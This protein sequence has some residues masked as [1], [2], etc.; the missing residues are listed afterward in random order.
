MLYALL[1]PLAVIAVTIMFLDR[2]G[3]PIRIEGVE[4]GSEP[5]A[6]D[7]VEHPPQPDQPQERQ[8]S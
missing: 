8:H 7:V 3:D 4:G 5:A 1:I 6:P 2:R